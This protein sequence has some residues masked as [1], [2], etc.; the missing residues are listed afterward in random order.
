MQ[1]E[2]AALPKIHTKR[3]KSNGTSLPSLTICV[4]Q[5]TFIKMIYH[6]L[7]RPLLNTWMTISCAAKLSDF[8]VTSCD[9]IT[10]S[11]RRHSTKMTS[12]FGKKPCRRS[13]PFSPRRKISRCDVDRSSCREADITSQVLL[14]HDTLLAALSRMFHEEGKRHIHVAIH[15]TSVFAQISNYPELHA[16]IVQNKMGSGVLSL[17][18]YILKRCMPSRQ[19]NARRRCRHLLSTQRPSGA[20]PK[21]RRVAPILISW[22]SVRSTPESQI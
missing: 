9:P 18:E 16:V 7:Q 17:L 22:G 20:A 5:M 21:A 4:A 15:I 3:V 8:V 14:L 12:R 2:R 1:D 11:S 19:E 6:L 13:L 10:T